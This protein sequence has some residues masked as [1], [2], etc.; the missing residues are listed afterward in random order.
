MAFQIKAVRKNVKPPVWRRMLIPEGITFVQLALILEEALELP[1]SHRFMF[2]FYRKIRVI[3]WK[4]EDATLNDYYYD[5]LNAADTFID[6]IFAE[7]KWFAFTNRDSRGEIPKYRIEIEKVIDAEETCPLILKEKRIMQ[8]ES[9]SD[10]ATI[11]QLFY[12]HYFPVKAEADYAMFSEVDT[13]IRNGS[14]L[15]VCKK[16]FNRDIHT[17]RSGQSYLKEA[18]ERFQ[19]GK[20]SSMIEQQ[21]E[22]LKNCL[23]FDPET[24][25]FR[26]AEEEIKAATEKMTGKLVTETGKEAIR[27]LEEHRPAELKGKDFR[28]QLLENYLGIFTREELIDS[29]HFID[30]HFSVKRK[31]KMTHELARYLLEP[32]TMRKLLMLM[33]E[34][35]MDA[36]ETA[37]EQ[38]L[39]KGTE[40]EFELL[41]RLIDLNYVAAY[42][43]DMVEVPVDVMM[44]YKIISREDY[45]EKRADK[46]WLLDCFSALSILHVVAP[47]DVLFRMYSQR[48]GSEK[49]RSSFLKLADTIPTDYNPCIIKNNKVIYHEVLKNDLY[50][51]LEERQRKIDFYI[52]TEQEIITVARKGYLPLE[53][54]YKAL[55]DFYIKKLKLSPELSRYYCKR[56]FD[57]FSMGGMLSDYLDILNETGIEF[58]SENQVREF[59]GLMMDVN[60]HTR[61]FELRGHTPLEM[62]RLISQMPIGQKTKVVPMS[63]QAAKLME[64]SREQLENMGLV[65]DT[66]SN[67]TSYPMITYQNGINSDGK[68]GIKKVYPNDPCPCGSGKKYKKCCGKNK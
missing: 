38:K 2:D 58:A 45:R 24:G 44:I 3:E 68:Q 18:M 31:D 43:D 9:W 63:T 4:E 34:E 8:D 48:K 6:G 15:F 66:E 46:K 10:G 28:Y 14:G 51:K 42:D 5:Y 33:T 11:N 12:D 35:E 37:M 1:K 67:A 22:E 21:L 20:I 65:V 61:M 30:F 36:F 57:V 41:N 39:H 7:E 49:N 25:L 26:A 50:K 40:K 23:D 16:P 19:K 56:A 60:N 55:H 52:P 62:G 29:A 54:S 64:E 13:Q 53:R 32:S 47:V 27:I 17:V 59:T